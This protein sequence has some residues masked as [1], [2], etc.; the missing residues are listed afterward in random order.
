MNLNTEKKLIMN[1]D[2]AALL[3]IGG[4][5]LR[6]GK[7]KASLA[8]DG[9]PLWEFQALKLREL[10]PFR[11]LI[12]ARLEQHMNMNSPSDF[13]GVE[14]IFDPPEDDLGP[15]GAVV[16]ALKLVS[17]PMLVLAV[18]MPLMEVSF[19]NEL[20][21]KVGLGRGYFY[22]GEN[23]VE[24]LCGVY[25]PCMLN[26]LDA[27]VQSRRLSLQKLV[28]EAAANDLATIASLNMNSAK[29]FENLNTPDIW[30]EMMANGRQA[31]QSTPP[32]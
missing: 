7:D 26:T 14:W 32:T 16:R 23:G 19:L 12:S 21:M 9:S 30:A 17:M 6:M 13:P 28:R 31:A 10:H 15:M 2:F 4:K 20:R 3:L 8:W 5:S 18:D 11:L 1:C 25:H 27:C 24:P 22:E 29:F